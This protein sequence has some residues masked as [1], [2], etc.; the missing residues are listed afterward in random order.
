MSEPVE[1]IRDR[2]RYFEEGSKPRA[3][4]RIGTEREKVMV[5]APD[6]RALPYSGPRGVEELLRRLSDRFGHRAGYQ[7]GHPLALRG[8]R[9]SITIEPGG[10]VDGSL[11]EASQPTRAAYDQSDGAGLRPV[12]TNRT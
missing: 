7:C 5:S 9:Y 8:E 4:W 2:I 1:S 12:R 11:Y 3:L 10:L 6:G